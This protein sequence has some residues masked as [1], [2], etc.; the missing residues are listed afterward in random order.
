MGFNPR[1][2][3][4]GD[5]I[6]IGDGDAHPVSIHALVRRA[7]SSNQE[8][9][10]AVFVSIHALVRRATSSNQEVAKAVFVSIHALVRRAT[11]SCGADV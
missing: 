4:E 11:F 1:P 7:T 2:R 6:D 9:A 5:G 10:K 3:T 8:V